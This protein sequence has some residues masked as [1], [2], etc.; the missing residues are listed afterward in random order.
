VILGFKDGTD[1]MGC[2]P[3]LRNKLLWQVEDLSIIKN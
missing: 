3:A 2:T 1:L